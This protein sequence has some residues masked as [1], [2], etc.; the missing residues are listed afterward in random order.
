MSKELR[1]LSEKYRKVH[2]PEFLAFGQGTSELGDSS[3]K[4]PGE[5]ALM[6][7]VRG[8]SLGGRGRLR[9]KTIAAAWV[10]SDWIQTRYLVGRAHPSRDANSGDNGKECFVS[11]MI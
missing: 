9:P 2:G 5:G 8:L 6:P 11:R 1:K 7:L 3:I 10:M 4:R